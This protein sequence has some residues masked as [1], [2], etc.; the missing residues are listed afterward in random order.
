M[1]PV[2]MSPC[3]AFW[4][5]LLFLNMRVS[6]IL[7][8]YPA[9]KSKK[10]KSPSAPTWVP[11]VLLKATKVIYCTLPECIYRYMGSTHCLNN[12]CQ[13]TEISL[14][15]LL[16]RLWFLPLFQGNVYDSSFSSDKAAITYSWMASITMD[17]P[18]LNIGPMLTY[19]L[20]RASL[21]FPGLK[22]F[23]VQSL[24]RIFSL[25][26]LATASGCQTRLEWSLSSFSAGVESNLPECFYHGTWKCT[27]FQTMTLQDMV[28]STTKDSFIND[29]YSSEPY[30]F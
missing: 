9:E 27:V 22:P 5:K 24:N 2:R 20:P 7:P 30:V 6:C 11:K 8:G 13:V 1:G 12:V 21:I 19:E 14:K 15:M 18:I 4:Y 29:V 25:N 3:S 28:T 23:P 17:L 10:S 26:W 16:E